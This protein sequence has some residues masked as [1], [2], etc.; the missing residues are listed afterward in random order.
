MNAWRYLID[1][2]GRERPRMGAPS[3]GEGGH[4]MP[5]G[6]KPMQTGGPQAPQPMGQ[7]MQTGGGLQ[8]QQINTKPMQIGQ[9]Q[10]WQTGGGNQPSALGNYMQTGGGMQPQQFNSP[11]GLLGMAQGWADL[12]S[13]YGFGW[14]NWR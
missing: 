8:P 12:P 11:Q 14:G 7:P 13:W 5:T 2:I 1:Q 6:F 10:Q 4:G 3:P 9:P